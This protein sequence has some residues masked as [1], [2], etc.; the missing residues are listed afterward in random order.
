MTAEA[1][2]N[3]TLGKRA[4]ALGDE[5]MTRDEICVGLGLLES[6]LTALEAAD[7]GFKQA[8]QDAETAAA[9]WLCR[10]VRE[11]LTARWDFSLWLA[12]MQWQWPE[13]YGPAA[14]APAPEKRPNWRR[15][16]PGIGFC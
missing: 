9:A 8:M 4:V 7:E 3:E 13:H 10:R 2:T 5:G 12:F 1:E 11:Q 16:R 6:E 14:K 15:W